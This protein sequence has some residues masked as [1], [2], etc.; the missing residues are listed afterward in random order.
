MCCLEYKPYYTLHTLLTPP[1]DGFDEAGAARA[2]AQTCP[3]F[4]VFQHLVRRVRC[5]AVVVFCLCEVPVLSMLRGVSLIDTPA[6]GGVSE[7]HCTVQ[8]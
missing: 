6:G 1:Q 3:T 2:A 5:V 8:W 7:L 4:E